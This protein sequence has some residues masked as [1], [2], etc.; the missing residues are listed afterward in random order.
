MQ[1]AHVVSDSRACRSIRDSSH[2][3]STCGCSGLPRAGDDEMCNILPIVAGQQP[4]G[5]ISLLRTPGLT[6]VVVIACMIESPLY[7]RYF[8]LWKDLLTTRLFSHCFIS[9]KRLISLLYCGLRIFPIARGL[10]QSSENVATGTAT[11]SSQPAPKISSFLQQL[12]PPYI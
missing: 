5:G 7:P 12:S 10:E 8:S 6:N 4:W 1:N 11:C 2:R 9:D 3:T